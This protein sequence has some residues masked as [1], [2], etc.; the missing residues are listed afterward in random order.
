MGSSTNTSTQLI[1]FTG[2]RFSRMISMAIK[3][4]VKIYR[5]VAR[6]GKAFHISGKIAMCFSVWI[7]C[8]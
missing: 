3:T 7:W 8:D 1:V 2:L 4:T 5:M 6:L